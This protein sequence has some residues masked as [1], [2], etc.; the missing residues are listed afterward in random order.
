MRPFGLRL[1]VRN[2]LF[3]TVDCVA[4]RLA[5]VDLAK[6]GGLDGNRRDHAGRHLSG[7]TSGQSLGRIQ[8]VQKTMHV[9]VLGH[10]VRHVSA[11]VAELG[12]R[13]SWLHDGD[14]DIELSDLLRHRLTETLDAELAS[15]IQA[16]RR[17]CHLTAIAGHLYDAAAA[18]LTH[19]R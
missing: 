15:V 10:E 8:H 17:E 6:R 7:V 9:V 11:A 13:P 14:A 16:V 18:L 19:M 12:A 1:V 5:A 3:Q 4:E 2:A